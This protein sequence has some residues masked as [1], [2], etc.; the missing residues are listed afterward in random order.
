MLE[1]SASSL[2]SYENCPLAYK[3]R[4]DWR[5]PEDAS[6][7]MQFG[8][9]MHLAL[10][11]YFDGVRAGRPLAEDSVIA[12]FLDE[13]AK[14]KIDDEVQ[15]N[16][17]TE[18]GREQLTA[19]LRSPLAR[20]ANQVLETERLFKVEIGGAKVKGR[21]DRVDG[22]ANGD[23]AIVDF[24]TGKA[25]TQDDADDSLQLSVY[26]LAAAKELGRTVSSLVFI[27]LDN[28]A[29]VES[30]RTAKQLSEAEEEVRT[31]AAQIAAGEFDPR[32]SGNCFRC[33][34]QTICPTQEEP[35]PRPAAAKTAKVN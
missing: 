20:P 1:L 29:A 9:A 19:F 18:Q 24:K 3:L 27:N 15:R 12:C 28:G 16:L 4:Y 7:P 26:A 13:F 22:L 8:N 30:R 31:I 25:K 34:Y 32:P 6:A 5:L 2:Q 21:F 10:K 35:L 33:S 11:A 23:I 17:Y 14:A